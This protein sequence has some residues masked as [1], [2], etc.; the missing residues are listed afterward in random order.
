MALLKFDIDPLEHL[1]DLSRPKGNMDPMFASYPSLNTMVDSLRIKK[2][3]GYAAHRDLGT[4]EQC[5]HIAGYHKQD[6]TKYTLFLTKKDLCK[7]EGASGKTFTYLTPQYTTGTI[8]S[9]TTTAVVGTGTLWDTD[10]AVEEGDYF[11][12]DDD[13]TSD[14]EPDSNWVR[15]ASVED[16]THLTLD[17]NYTLNGT[18][19]KIR[20]IYSVPTD[21]RWAWCVADDKFIFSSGSQ[22]TQV[23]TGTGLAAALNDPEADRA[24][25]MIEYANRLI[26]ADIYVSDTREPWS[27]RFSMLTDPTDFTDST[28]GQIDFTGTADFMTGL[29]VVGTQLMVYKQDSYHPG[30]RTGKSVAPLVFPSHVRGVGVYA[31]YSLVD[32][33]GTNAF[34]WRD[35]FYMMAGDRPQPIGGRIRHDFFNLVEESDL[36][37]VWGVTMAR[38]NEVMWVAETTDGKLAFVFDYKDKEWGIYD[39]WHD[40]VG[41]GGIT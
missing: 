1:H 22:L 11:I 28:A 40:I 5:Q 25:Y 12:M 9:I 7:S 31:P 14:V 8:V 41:A 21:E 17:S 20:Q 10:S 3:W 39:F 26:I 27:L 34:L 2:R 38:Q 16:D 37:N 19:Y 30:Q 36:P 23:W 18:A 24:R 13:H 15:I 6:D 32:V 4:G 33:L 35:D 29:G